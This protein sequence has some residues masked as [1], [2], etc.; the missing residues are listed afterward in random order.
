MPLVTVVALFAASGCS[1]VNAPWCDRRPQILSAEPSLQEIIGVT[2]E[3]TAR[4]RSLATD[5]ATIRATHSPSLR[6]AI[7]LEPRPG[8]PPNLR[9]R[10]STALTGSELDVGSNSELFWVWL[11]RSEPKALYFARHDQ[12]AGSAMHRMLPVTPEQLVAALGLVT[13]GADGSHQGPFRR[14]PGKLAIRSVVA[15]SGGPQTIVTEVDDRA[16]WVLAQHLY[17]AGGAHLATVTMSDHRLDPVS[18]VT[19]PRRVDMHWPAR[20]LDLSIV[21]GQYDINGPSVR[22]EE[23]ALPQYDNYPPVD[24]ARTPPLP[25]TTQHRRAAVVDEPTARSQSSGWSP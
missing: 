16:G 17:D 23:F 18:G 1:C 19:L 7:R 25:A 22:P 12:F 11:R 21:A 6:A 10:A 3:N 15:S 4:V 13:L 24:L 14:A 2:N 5:H 8:A 20:Q 9:L